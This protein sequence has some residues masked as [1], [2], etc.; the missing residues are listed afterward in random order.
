MPWITVDIG[1]A[2]QKEENDRRHADRDAD[3]VAPTLLHCH[4]RAERVARRHHTDP[5]E[6][7]IQ[8]RQRGSVRSDLNRAAEIENLPEGRQRGLRQR[9]TGRR[10]NEINQVVHEDYRDAKSA[11]RHGREPNERC[12]QHHAPAQ[13]PDDA[14]KQVLV[15]M[16]VESPTDANDCQLQQNENQSPRQE[17]LR[18]RRFAAEFLPQ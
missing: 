10:R 6:D 17:V 1:R 8:N 16:E 3:V 11:D 9:L 4:H 15:E 18:K 5:R 14:G 7:G 13:H 2:Q 12:H